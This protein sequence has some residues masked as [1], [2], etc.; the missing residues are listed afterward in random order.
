MMREP[1]DNPLDEAIA[2]A[3]GA[4]RPHF[5]ADRWKQ[6]HPDAVRRIESWKT[7]SPRAS[8]ARGW[9]RWRNIMHGRTRKALAVAV[10]IVAAGI[11]G[12]ILVG[13]GATVA[14][15]D[16]QE[17]IAAQSWIHMVFEDTMEVWV[18]LKDGRFFLKHKEFCIAAYPAKKTA[19]VYF[20]AGKMI[21]EAPMPVQGGKWKPRTAWEYVVDGF[22]QLSKHAGDS[23]R[24]E[25]QDD[26]IDG[27]KMVRFDV[28]SR[29][30]DRKETLVGQLW[31][32]PV[33][34]LPVRCRALVQ[35]T[36]DGEQ[37]RRL[38]TGVCRFPQ[39]GPESIYDLG[40]PRD[41]A[42]LRKTS[43]PE[44]KRIAASSG[45]AWRAFPRCYRAVIWS[46]ER[47]RPV[48]LI[49]RNGNKIRYERYGSAS[50]KHPASQL[51]ATASAEQV[52]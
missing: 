40:V 52:V 12:Y 31:A 30:S 4:D 10:V 32:D 7:D 26:S 14:L 15:A 49:H 43:N 1:D 50:R 20:Q 16:V 9:Q 3:V 5:D 35:M 48:E 34:R 37:T 2:R 18:S 23:M 47:G 42:N 44:I 38:I 51:S 24:V 17:A 41:A 29:D 6:Q 13:G 27:R 28:Y 36:R 25:R 11:T 21:L 46:S 33:R 22:Q 8:R 45:Q 39:K 19:Q